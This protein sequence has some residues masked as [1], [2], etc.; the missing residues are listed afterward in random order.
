MSPW[1]PELQGIRLLG[2]VRPAGDAEAGTNLID[3]HGM[4]SGLDVR[5]ELG[6]VELPLLPVVQNVEQFQIVRNSECS[7]GIPYPD[8]ADGRRLSI[9]EELPVTLRPVGD[10]CVRDSISLIVGGVY[11]MPGFSGIQI[12]QFQE[13]LPEKPTEA[14]RR[15]GTATEP[16]KV[17]CVALLV[18][19][20]QPVVSAANVSADAGTDGPARN[21]VDE[22]A[23]TADSRVVVLQL[24]DI[25]N[26]IPLR[27]GIE[28]FQH[29]GRCRDAV[30]FLLSIVPRSVTTDDKPFH[31]HL[32]FCLPNPS[33][34]QAS[35]ERTVMDESDYANRVD[36]GS[37]LGKQPA[38]HLMSA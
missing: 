16:E 30:L 17:D 21:L 3:G 11:A 1:E 10:C 29:V 12:R 15:E 8:E 33:F 26:R 20:A 37:E 5:A 28:N 13:P 35:W 7:H 2:G 25:L 19:Q 14:P 9:V 27:N 24:L 32:L 6:A 34:P 4:P 36:G 22:P 31:S 23:F 18:V 38:P